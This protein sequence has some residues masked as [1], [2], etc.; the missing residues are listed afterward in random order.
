MFNNM[1]P[2]D[3]QEYININEKELDFIAKYNFN[4]IRLP[5]DYRFWIHN[6]KY[7]EP[8]EKMLKQVDRCVNAIITRDIHCSLNL[9]RAPGYCINN[10]QLERHNLW[11]NKNAQ[12]AFVHQ[13]ELFSMRYKNISA[14][15]LSFDLLNEPPDIGQYGI[16][17]ENHAS[18]MRRTVATIRNINLDRPIVLD[19]LGGGNICIPEL[20]D[21]KIIMSG[22]GYQPMALTHYQAQWCENVRNFPYPVYPGTFYEGKNW[23]K[24]TIK[25][26]YQPWKELMDNGTRIHI[27]EFG[28]YNKID[29]SLALRWF[30]DILD[31][32]NEYGFGYALWNFKGDFG[33]I[34]HGR[35]GTKWEMID[36]FKVDR[37]LFELLRH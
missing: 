6:F 26:Y 14:E 30:N 32:F 10:N 12:D 36:G 37:E 29:N 15:K 9:H 1:H 2:A 8:D 3:T 16:T 24:D 21:L 25:N 13:W 22:R 23:N 11:T 7:D 34:E 17:R 19:G 33:I 28:C 18:L 35:K 20:A 31:I 5:L 27:G 4:F